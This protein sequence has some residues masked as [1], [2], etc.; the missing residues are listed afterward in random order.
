MKVVYPSDDVQNFFFRPRKRETTVILSIREEGK[1]DWANYNHEGVF[2]NGFLKLGVTHLFKEGAQYQFI[3]FGA[4]NAILWRGKGYATSQV[5]ESYKLHPE[6]VFDNVP[7]ATLPGGTPTS[8]VTPPEGTTAINQLLAKVHEYEYVQSVASDT[9]V[10]T[11][12]LNKY[13]S[14]TVT[15][16][17]GSVLYGD[18]EYV[19]L[20][21]VR[22]TFSTPITGTAKLN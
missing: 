2:E 6:L 8:T 13:P 7:G 16:S 3:V 9:W 14:V 20:S 5:A 15:D 12:T 11:H 18:V 4:N 1:D 21:Q 19:S 10:I 17:A 22:I